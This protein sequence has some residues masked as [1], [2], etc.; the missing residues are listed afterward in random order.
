MI[1]QKWKK[2]VKSLHQKKYRDQEKLFLV[3]GEKP[4]LE[5]LTSNFHIEKIFVTD[6]FLKKNPNFLQDFE[7]LSASELAQIS[8]M[9]NNQM[10]LAIVRQYEN[11]PLYPD[12]NI[13]LALDNIQDPGNLG[14]ILRIC[15]WYGIRKVVC[16][17]Q[18]VDLYNLKV[19]NASKGSFLRVQC[20]YTNL[21]NYLKYC[22][23]NFSEALIYASTLQGKS[24]Y[25]IKFQKPAILIMGNEARGISEDILSYVK[26]E[27]SIPRPKGGGAE[28]LNVAIATAIIVDKFFQ[29][30]K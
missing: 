6:L 12:N 24:V 9:E 17:N 28:S 5:L 16:N 10:A 25:E 4:I 22:V 27:I 29:N 15:D 23:E 26:Q 14:T 18:T 19:I 20:F 11:K 21:Q 1:S 2:L 7:I 30:F 8:A 3:E 13:I